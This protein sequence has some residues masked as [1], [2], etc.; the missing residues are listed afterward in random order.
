MKE[1]TKIWKIIKVATCGLWSASTTI[2]HRPL[3]DPARRYH[4]AL[5]H[6]TNSHDVSYCLFHMVLEVCICIYAQDNI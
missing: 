6:D 1:K 3:L 5:L 4:N 2:R